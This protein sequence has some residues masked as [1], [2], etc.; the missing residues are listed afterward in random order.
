MQLHSEYVKCVYT[1]PI[2]LAETTSFQDGV[3][4]AI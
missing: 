1:L 3:S 2:M 4:M